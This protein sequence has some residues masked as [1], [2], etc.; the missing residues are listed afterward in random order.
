MLNLATILTDSAF[1]LPN[2][3]AF[4]FGDSTLTYAQMEAT[5]NQIA[6]GLVHKGIQ[7]GDKI[8]LSCFNLPYFP[9][10]YYGILKAGAV[11]VPLSVLLKEDEIEY[12]L[13]DSEAKA[14][15]CFEGSLDLPMGKMGYAGFSKAPKCKDFIMITANPAASSPIEGTSTLGALM[16]N[17]S[18]KF[19]ISR[20]GAEDTAVI[21]YTSGTTGKPKG[22]L[23][24]MIFVC[25]G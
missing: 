7:P 10:I 12:H 11:V 4:T 18:P 13:N 6:N 15:F 23:I 5:S 17:Q 3:P 21:I 2:H 9:M 24:S 1:R 25:L 20:T 8:A 19:E 22:I 16:A 14:Y